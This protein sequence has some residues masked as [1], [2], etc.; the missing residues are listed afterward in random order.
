MITK[1][2]Y[3]LIRVSHEDSE[4]LR[5]KNVSNEAGIFKMVKDGNPTAP[6]L[7]YSLDGVTWTTYD[8][9]TLPEVS[10][11]PASNIYFRGT[12]SNGQF[13]KSTSAYVKFSFNKTC[14]VYGNVCSLFNPDPAVFPTITSIGSCGLAS[15]FNGM[16][17]LTKAPNF[18]SI[19]TISS[20]SLMSCFSGC[21]SLIVGP[22]FSNITSITGAQ[23][24]SFC[25]GS[26]SKISDVTAPNISDLTQN[27]ILYNWLEYAGSQAAG[28]K[29]VR[30]PTGSTIDTN[31]N[32][33][34]PT[35][36]TR[37]DY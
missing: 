29:V 21:T 33:G 28:T 8:F 13:N 32:S 23:A 10:V 24:V 15:L 16:T 26:C 31:S 12:N 4:Y 19:T 14:E 1:K 22:D 35:G 9:S 2:Y 27:N 36:W 3:K 6:N 37:V 34:I 25:F 30:V 11:A 18:S 5:L 17:T 20:F 7:E